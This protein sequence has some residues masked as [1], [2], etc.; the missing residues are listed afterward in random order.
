[1]PRGF[2]VK[3]SKRAPSISYRVRS[4]DD[5]CLLD[6]SSTARETY[7]Q[8]FNSPDSGYGHSPCP[9]SMTPSKEEE[10][11]EEVVEKNCFE[12][13]SAMNS[14]LSSLPVEGG[15][16]PSSP[17][18]PVARIPLSAPPLS[19]PSKRPADEMDRQDPPRKSIGS[20]PKKPKAARRITFDDDNRSPVHGTI[21]KQLSDDENEEE[22]SSG[23]KSLGLGGDFMCKLC[24]EQYQDPFSL[25]QHK[26]SRIVHVEYRCPECDKVF[27]C[28]ANLASHRRWH[29]PRPVARPQRTLTDIELE[30]TANAAGRDRTDVGA[31]TPPGDQQLKQHCISKLL[32]PESNQ[33]EAK[34][35]DTFYPCEQCNKKFRRPANLRKHLQ[36]HNEE[37]VYPCHYCGKVFGSL[38]HRT[39]HMF[40]HAI[41]GHQPSFES[42]IVKCRICGLA[43]GDAVA[44]SQHERRH[45]HHTVDN[46][47]HP[48]LSPHLY[49]CKYCSTIFSDSM[50][51]AG[52]IDKRHPTEHRRTLLLN[53]PTRM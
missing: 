13:S 21:I 51:L 45:H 42:S 4:I 52:H 43:F 41:S 17:G 12:T 37:D 1:M 44:L 27:N 53:V 22:T 16:Y 40:T 28:P 34:K 23:G 33:E 31:T 46:L 47:D 2:L 11:E 9:Q 30:E 38:I 5:D 14:L 26:C 10:G 3:R 18:L 29:K 36:Q 19:R 48:N 49:P 50:S 35:E 25:A 32:G 7:S 39:K 15:S 8:P 20:K 24:K 6:L